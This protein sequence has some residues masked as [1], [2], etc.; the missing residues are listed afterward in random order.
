MYQ[1]VNCSNV[2]YK[3]QNFG[4]SLGFGKRVTGKLKWPLYS[5]VNFFLS[6]F[7]STRSRGAM[8]LKFCMQA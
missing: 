7:F 5:V 8:V 4:T 6:F 3:V 1:K 2:T